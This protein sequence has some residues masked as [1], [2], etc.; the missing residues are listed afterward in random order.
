M[1]DLLPPCKICQDPSS[2][3]HYG[4]A[5][6]DACKGFF[7]RRL[8]SSVKGKPCFLQGRCDIRGSMKNRCAPCRYKTCLD[9]GMSKKELRHCGENQPEQ[10][11]TQTVTSTVTVGHQACLL[12]AIPVGPKGETVQE[13]IDTL[14]GIYSSLPSHLFTPQEQLDDKIASFWEKYTLKES[15]FGKMSAISIE[16]YTEIYRTTGLDIDD[17]FQLTQ[18]YL[19]AVKRWM[20]KLISFAKRV[21]GFRALELEDQ[22]NLIKYNRFEFWFLGAYKGYNATLEAAVYPNG[23]CLHKEDIR[24]VGG[25]LVPY[26]YLAWN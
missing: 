25:T 13:I 11:D 4:V 3:I 8:K 9:A 15:L 2:G 22:F 20:T 19:K 5:S 18:T 1:S 23:L 10:P 17:R 6:C 16:E 14:V 21:P 26:K 7:C 12:S 24:K